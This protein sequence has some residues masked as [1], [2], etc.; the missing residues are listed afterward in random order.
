MLGHQKVI[1]DLFLWDA[2][3]L[4]VGQ[5]HDLMLVSSNALLGL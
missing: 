4:T 2:G 5:L 3:T 1:G